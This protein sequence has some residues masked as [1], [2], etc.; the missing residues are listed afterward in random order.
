MIIFRG[1]T[2]KTMKEKIASKGFIIVI[3]KKACMD[4]YLMFVS[5]Q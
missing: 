2:N 1:K 3:L 5:Y 4:E